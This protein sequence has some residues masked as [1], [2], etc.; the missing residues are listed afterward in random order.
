[1]LDTTA[2]ILQSANKGYTSVSAPCSLYEVESRASPLLS[3]QLDIRELRLELSS[4]RPS[5]ANG[6]P[7]SNSFRETGPNMAGW[8]AKEKKLWDFQVKEYERVQRNVRKRE[9]RQARDRAASDRM[10]KKLD[11]K[12]RRSPRILFPELLR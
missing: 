9:E 1:M 12:Y 11:D 3:G 8:T 10:R 7:S 2:V 6:V 4:R 5:T